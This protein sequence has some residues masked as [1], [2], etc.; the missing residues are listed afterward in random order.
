[1]KTLNCLFFIL[2]ADFLER[3]RRTSYRV[4]LCLA[5]YIGYAVNSAQ[6]LIKLDDYR[7]VYNSAWV[8]SLMALTITFLLGVFGFF[9]VKDT[10]NRDE[11]T[12]VG[13]ILA[14]TSLSRAEY[15][16]GKWLSNLSVLFSLV[17]IL[18]LAAVVM[19]LFYREDPNF[20]LWALLAP[21][22][23]ISL[24]MMAL[25][26]ALAVF[27]ECVPW[28]KGGF[29]NLVYF[30]VFIFL[31]VVSLYLP[32]YPWLDITGFSQ[33][34]SSM[35]AAAHAAIPE[36]DGNFVFSMAGE[37]A[38]KTFVWPGLNW[39]PALIFQRLAWLGISALL[40]L[41]GIPFFNRFDPNRPL[42]RQK[43]G[44][45]AVELKVQPETN[46]TNT[47][48]AR[49]LTP[50]PA[51]RFHNN[52]FRLVWLECLLTLKG[53]K[54]YWT[55]GL[56]AIWLGCVLG[57]TANLRQIS[58]MLAVIWPVLLW[59]KMG[60]RDAAY[61][62]EQ[63]IF[64]TAHPVTRTLIANW[65]AGALL[66]GLAASGILLGRLLHGQSLDL[67]VWLL[68]VLFIPSL[69]LV[70]GAWSRS[71][72][73]FEVIYPVLWYL[74]PMN[75]QNGLASI[76]YLGIHE[77]ALVNTQPLVFAGL[78]LLLILLALLGRQ[79]AQEK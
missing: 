64:Q 34:G 36:Y 1:M 49:H 48:S 75:P 26:A 68:S 74:G 22:V 5:L 70:L 10:L 53:S 39:T 16:F 65:L 56:A 20:Q 58:F 8:G 25:V 60:Q 52:V 67:G 18:S 19:Q 7:G 3:S 62:T 29:G 66:S 47:L 28:L 69:A 37:N 72:K 6:I 30:F 43:N 2:K 41:A 11:R 54:W 76:D 51:G 9:L 45:A 79:L 17:G 14:T 44:Q 12:G 78:S 33:I 71:S 27:F 73:L 77:K 38:L 63:L 40:A 35:R 42:K 59:S 57:P 13:Q 46:I 4:A 55:L 50:L 31:F 61:R 24:P 32:Q 15:L 21:L 23:L